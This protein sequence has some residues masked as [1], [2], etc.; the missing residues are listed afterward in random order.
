MQKNFTVNGYNLD[1]HQMQL[2]NSNENCIIIAGAGAGKTLTILGKI[3]YLIEYQNIKPNEILVLSFTNAS[4]NDI[5][6]K[7]NNDISVF[8]FHKLA[9]HILKQCQFQYT[10]C[11]PTLLAYIIK[12]SVNTAPLN[13]QKLILRYLHFNEKY[14]KFLLSNTCKSF[15]KYVESFINL[16]KT[17]AFSW[18]NLQF[19]NLRKREK[20]ILLY[21]FS[22]YKEY[23]KEKA[24]TKALDFDDLILAATKEVPN[25]NFTYKYIIIDEFQDTSQIRLN[26]VKELVK[27]THAKI[28]VVGDDWQSIYH[29]SG[30]NLAIFLNFTHYFSNV[31][32]IKLINTY[33]NSQELINI[34]STFIKKNPIQIDKSLKSL[35]NNSLPLVFVPYHNPTLSFKK[36]LDYLLNI[37]NDIMVLIRNNNDIFQYID[38]DF[39][40]DNGNLY[41]LN[42]LLKLFTVHKSKGLESEYVVILNCNEAYL[43]FP[44]KIENDNL[45]NKIFEDNEIPF[46]E[47]RRLFYVALTRC[48][49]QTYL[50]YNAKTPSRFIKEIK[51]ITKKELGII[52]FFDKN[53]NSF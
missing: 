19:K 15:L 7:I 1:I 3:N 35:K 24:S 36:V 8:T 41:Y 28:I 6:S 42:H 31:K 39:H 9:I 47:E 51:K 33:R 13:I 10:I 44:N 34:A 30:C 50:L 53:T 21:M 26:L 29:F 52:P 49:I 11:S 45:I 2:I 17:N 4:V 37:T 18:Q 38:N 43:G 14:P 25:G 40:F 48:K 20:Q 16:W 22:I 32:T 5:K 23:I 12:E 27:Y 46:A